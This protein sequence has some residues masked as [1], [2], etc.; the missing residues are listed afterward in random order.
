MQGIYYVLSIV[1]VFIVLWWYV[2][3]DKVK[4]SEPTTGLLAMKNSDS[5][6]SPAK[7]NRRN[8]VSDKT[9]PG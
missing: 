4:D 6:P 7:R 9:N 2:R 1:G 8:A 3:N 5:Q